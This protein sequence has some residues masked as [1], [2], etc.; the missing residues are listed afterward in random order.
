VPRAAGTIAILPSLSPIVD[1]FGTLIFIIDKSVDR[2]ALRA[3]SAER[4][5]RPAS[6]R[7]SGM[8]ER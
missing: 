4:R 5:D 6:L 7:Y 1:I 8:F 2:R 3:S